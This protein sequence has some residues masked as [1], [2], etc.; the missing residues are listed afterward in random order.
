MTS[1]ALIL[2][3]LPVLGALIVL[4]APE[5]E[6]IAILIAVTVVTTAVALV[7][8]GSALASPGEAD[9]AGPVLLDLPGGVM[10]GVAALVG[11]A[12]AIASPGYVRDRP[13]HRAYAVK[14]LAFWAVS[15]ALPLADNLGV[16][17]VLV[18]ASTAVSALLVAFG[19]TTRALE[20]AWKY[21]VLTTIGLALTL[22]GIVILA[23]G[24]ASP[25][26]SPRSTGA[27]SRRRPACS[28]TTRPSSPTSSSSAGS[29]PR[30][31]GRRSTT[32]C[33][34]HTREAPAPASALL[35][36]VLLPEVL[37]IAWRRRSR[38]RR[39]SATTPRGR[40]S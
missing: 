16:A 10:A 27:R 35:S 17:W 9:S 3:L 25:S 26:A 8:A 13:R 18:E 7:V 30:S 23:A 32:G 37:L 24:W 29:P 2:P 11:L 22:F 1:L 39:P 40:R 6:A 12:A 36:A 21:L 31:A 28:T 38:S 15:L 20:A 19:A 34:T 14:L 4:A 33:P 5:G